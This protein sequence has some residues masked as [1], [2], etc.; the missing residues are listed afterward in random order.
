MAEQVTKI[1]RIREVQARI[2]GISRNE[3][4]RR[5]RR[6]QFPRQIK[7]GEKSSGWL[8]HEVEAWIQQKIAESRPA[9]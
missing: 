1:L 5:I 6:G 9:A 4:Y 3:L 7:L 2:G 8:E